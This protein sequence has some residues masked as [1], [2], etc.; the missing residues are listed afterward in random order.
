MSFGR[1]MTFAAPGVCVRKRPERSR[2]SQKRLD[3]DRVRGGTLPAG[4]YATLVHVGPYDG[5]IDANAR[6]QAWA[7]EQGHVFACE[8]PKWDGRVERSLNDPTAEPNP[9]KWQ[10]EVA[11]LLASA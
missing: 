3:N 10:T 1:P 6:L 7:R 11:Y 9:A 4:R 2:P 8:G 5:L